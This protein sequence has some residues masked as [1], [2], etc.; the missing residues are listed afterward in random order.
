MNTS[1]LVV[2][3]DLAVSMHYVL[4]DPSGAILDQSDEGE[5][6]VYLHGY[7]N[8]VPGLE[9]KLTG[10]SI[11][12]SR[13]VVVAPEDGYGDRDEEMVLVVPRDQLPEDLTPEVGM[14]LGMESDDGDHLPVTIV[15]VR[16]DE[17]VL[18]ANHELAGVT[19]HFSVTIADIRAATS[20]ELAH[21]HVHGPDD[22]HH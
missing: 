13:E 3:D 8:I 10:L 1:K 7:D 15:E 20:E 14:V 4:R 6:L 21:G 19:L 18:D 9:R 12:D 16:Q 17:V 11:G 2:A 22:H 5:P